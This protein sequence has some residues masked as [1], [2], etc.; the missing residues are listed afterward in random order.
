MLLCQR[1]HESVDNVFVA[2]LCWEIATRLV[3]YTDDAYVRSDLI[4]VAPQV[5]GRILAV[6]VRDNQEVRRGDLL[7]SIDPEPF[8]FQVEELSANP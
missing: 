6:H 3:A 1:L 7:V 5:T 2:F 8:R 4:G